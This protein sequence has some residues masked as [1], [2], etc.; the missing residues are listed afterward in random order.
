MQD[1]DCIFCKIIKKEIPSEIIKETENVL[2]IKDIS[3]KAPI[4]YLI[5]PKKHIRNLHSLTDQDA[6]VSYEMLKI[7]RDVAREIQKKNGST[8]PLPFNL[9]VNNEAEAG[10]CVFHLHWHFVSGKNIFIDG[11]KL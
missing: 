9:L 7:A 1:Q 2:V 3:P 10:Q 11:S 6:K 8:K 5:L 4:H